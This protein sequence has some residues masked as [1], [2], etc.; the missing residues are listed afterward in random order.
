[1]KTIEPLFQPKTLEKHLKNFSLEDIPDYKKMLS[2]L[3]NWKISI[4][5]SDLERTKE[6]AVQGLF[7]EQI[8]S[9]ILG[10]ASLIGNKEYNIEQEHTSDIDGTEADSALGFFTTKAKDVRAVM[11]LKDAMKDLD[12]KQ[13]R[14]NPQTP[15][16]Q[17][18]SYMLKT[19]S[20][21]KWVIVSNF[22]EIRL[23]HRNTGMTKCQR[24]LT[25]ELSEPEKFKEFYFIL[26]RDHLMQKS[27]ESVTDRL[28]QESANA[29]E[30]ISKKF[31]ADYSDLRLKLFHSLVEHNPNVEPLVIFS[32]TQKLMDRFI[33]VCFCEDKDLLPASIF[34]QVIDNAQHS[35][36]LSQNKIWEQMKNL[37]QSIDQGNP[38]A[39][40]NHFNGGL[41]QA[42]E[43]L[44]SLV[45]P[46]DVLLMV[47]TLSDY[48]FESDLNV[49]ILGHIFEHSIADIEKIKAEING[50]DVQDSKRK[51]DGIYYTPAYVTNYIVDQTIGRWMRDTKEKIQHD[52]VADGYRTHTRIGKSHKPVDFVTLNAW[53]EIP[54]KD[55][56]DK[57]HRTAVIH[58]HISMLEQYSDKLRELRVLDPA[59][60]SGAFLNSAFQYIWNEVQRVNRELDELRG[61]SIGLF[62]IDKQILE[63]NLYGVDINGES[64]E[65]TKL[66]LWL[67]TANKNKPLTALDNA[68]KCGNSLI[69]DADV[70]KE[71]A[72]DW[73]KE[74]S[75]I[76]SNGGFDVIIGNP[77]YGA[78][79]TQAEKDY[80]FQHYASTQGGVDTYKTFFELGLKL[81]KPDGYLGYITPNT[82]LM[83]DMSSYVRKYLFEHASMTGL[84]EL[85]NVFPDAVV[86]PV[87]TLWKKDTASRNDIDVILVPRK[88]KLNQNFLSYGIRKTMAADTITE[89]NK[90][91][92]DYKQDDGDKALYEKISQGTT[93]I[94]DNFQ[95]VTGIELYGIGKGTPPQTKETLETKPFTCFT[96]ED[97]TCLPMVRGTN[98]RYAA[99][100]E[101]EYVKYGPWLRIPK[102]RELFEQEKLLLR[103]TGDYPLAAYDNTNLIPERAS[104]ALVPLDGNEMNIKFILGLLNSTLTKWIFQYQNSQLV[105]K[106]LAQMNVKYLKNLPVK[107]EP[108]S[109]VPVV[110]ELI[111]LHAR[112]LE[113][114]DSFLGFIHDNY[115]IEKFS[116]KMRKYYDYDVQTFLG[117][118]HKKK[119]NLSLKEKKDF[120]PFF[121]D[122]AEQ[123]RSVISQIHKEDERLDTLF[124]HLYGLD[125]KDVARIQDDLSRWNKR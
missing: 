52:L 93:S 89:S 62:D 19:K 90:Y 8:F 103:R 80:I 102:T 17:G 110:D 75:G 55:S 25:V 42:D 50:E 114:E 61:G 22:K 82:F 29:E 28:F 94:S 98:E 36:S 18:F 83:Q 70:D 54:D 44:D 124:F 10:Y 99:H 15:V 40:I 53:E 38:P 32:K 107:Y 34:R 121:K 68:V 92:V 59:C 3:S 104:H 48:D 4:E 24:F 35:F 9:Q 111:A 26:S 6:T 33:F 112:K 108:E 119:V 81:L 27:G 91:V 88:T 45:V 76:L 73:E 77:P 30:D 78:S 85:Y 86:E 109:I 101:G 79:Q 7:C 56:S 87:I 20:D 16:E 47:K 123:I 2:R 65:I 13:H 64:I 97:D 105:G 58:M 51:K 57:K 12:A 66:S 5:N 118:M 1:M 125:E 69:P 115:G 31:Y 43:V 41:F 113:L 84:V 67:Q 72:F 100:W 46:D 63:Q 96:K 117:E 39:G 60:G 37:F 95:I 120:T 71:H 11:E 116:E 23:Y 106:P 49:N 14:K 122:E 21:C 74:F